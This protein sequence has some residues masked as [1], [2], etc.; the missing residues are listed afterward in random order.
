M[1]HFIQLLQFR[2]GP[3]FIFGCFNLVAALVFILLTRFSNIVVKGVNAWYKPFKFALSIGTF[4]WTMGWYTYELHMPGV[5]N[6]YNWAVIFLLGFE[7]AYIAVQAGRGQT[8]HYNSSSPVYLF[9][10]QMMGLA[11]V[12]VT[13]WT[14]YIGILF[15]NADFPHLPDYY[16]WAIRMSIILFV[17]F[18]FEGALMGI[19]ESHTVGGTDGSSGLPLLNWSKKYG[20]LRIAHFIGMH[21]LQVLPL[22]AWYVLKNIPATVVAGLLYGLLSVYTLIRALKG[23][24]LTSPSF[25]TGLN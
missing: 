13:L 10:Y 18:S 11:A 25:S 12:L 2:N 6:P 8:S 16:V 9:L 14:G 21:A 20:D 23:K 17:I 24:P 5:V 7:V 4:S 1:N 22:L 3:L 19:K 15:F